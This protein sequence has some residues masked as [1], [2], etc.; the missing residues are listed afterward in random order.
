MDLP[1]AKR[2][3]IIVYPKRGEPIEMHN[4]MNDNYQGCCDGR[5]NVQLEDGSRKEFQ[6]HD[7]RWVDLSPLLKEH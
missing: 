4:T 3:Y 2:K 7:I 1:M 6:T 5:F